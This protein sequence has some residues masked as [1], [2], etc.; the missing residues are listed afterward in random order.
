MHATFFSYYSVCIFVR[1][2]MDTILS[3]IW[4]LDS[5]GYMDTVLYNIHG[6]HMRSIVRQLQLHMYK[7]IISCFVNNR[8]T[9][10]SFSNRN[11]QER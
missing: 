11:L 10:T 3:C 4:M 8:Y 6:S 7:T 1:A 2:Y 9:C 5:V